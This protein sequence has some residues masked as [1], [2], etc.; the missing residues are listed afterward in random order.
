MK[1]RIQLGA[2][3]VLVITS[4]RET[5]SKLSAHGRWEFAADLCCG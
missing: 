3:V 2:D 4:E 5:A 1:L